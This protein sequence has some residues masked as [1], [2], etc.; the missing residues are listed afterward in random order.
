VK[1]REYLAGKWRGEQQLIM[2]GVVE[3]ISKLRAC[4]IG[5]FSDSTAA[6]RRELW[7]IF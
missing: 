4:N 1:L 6:E 2:P 5:M 3:F 7:N